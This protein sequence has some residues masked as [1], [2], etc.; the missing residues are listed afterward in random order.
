MIPP[1]LIEVVELVG[2]VHPKDRLTLSFSSK[3]PNTPLWDPVGPV[4]EYPFD[5]VS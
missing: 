2:S 1:S 4:E 3:S 5:A